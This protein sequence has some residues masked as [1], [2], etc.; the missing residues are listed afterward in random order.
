MRDGTCGMSKRKPEAGETLYSLNVGGAARRGEQKLTPMTVLHV[1]RKWFTCAPV[2]S[3]S[4][5]QHVKFCVETW[6]QKTE[7]CPDHYLYETPNDWDDDREAK[8]IRDRLRDTFSGFNQ[9]EVSIEK[10]RKIR[11]ILES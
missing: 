7:Y 9:V 2:G 6:R 8:Q 3:T 4:E 1:G 11:D 10:L 5:W